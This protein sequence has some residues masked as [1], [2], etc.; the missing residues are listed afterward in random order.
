MSDILDMIMDYEQGELELEE[1]A[2]LFQKLVDSGMIHSLQG[3]YQRMAQR[4]AQDG[5]ITLVR[6]AET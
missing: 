2:D 3:H 6:S 5:W 4:L 1:I